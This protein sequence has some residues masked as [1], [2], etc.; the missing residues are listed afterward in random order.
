VILTVHDEI[1]CEVPEGFGEVEQ[2]CAIMT[3]LPAW[4]AGCPVAAEGWEAERY[5]K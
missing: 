3:E 2:F 1:V 4:A 5:R